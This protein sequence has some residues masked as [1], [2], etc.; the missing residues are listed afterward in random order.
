MKSKYPLTYQ[1]LESSFYKKGE[2]E[3]LSDVRK[4]AVINLLLDNFRRHRLTKMSNFAHEKIATFMLKP[5][6]S[7]DQLSEELI[8]DIWAS[9][10]PIFGKILKKLGRSVYV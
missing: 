6:P 7:A 5:F 2:S 10:W 3:S 1:H 8:I 9:N 4:Q